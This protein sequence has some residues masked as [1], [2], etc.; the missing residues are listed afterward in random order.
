MT[1]SGQ[2]EGRRS[3]CIATL[4]IF[5]LFR[6]S[7]NVVRSHVGVGHVAR[8]KDGGPPSDIPGGA[9]QTGARCHFYSRLNFGSASQLIHGF[10]AQV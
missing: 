1:I 8:R 2:K 5:S 4:I 10:V 9:G 7:P 3:A 6:P